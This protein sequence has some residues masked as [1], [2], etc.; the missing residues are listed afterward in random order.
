[1]TVQGSEIL[2]ANINFLAYESSAYTAAN[3]SGTVTTTATDGTIT[4]AAAHNLKVGDPVNFTATTVVTTVTGT[5]TNGNI[6]VLSSTG[7]VINMPVAFTG[8]TFG[9][10][11]ISTVYYIRSISG[12]TVTLS[13]AYPASGSLYTPS[14]TTTGSATMTVGGLFVTCLQQTNQQVQHKFIML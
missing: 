9:G 11:S 14:S 7:M 5:N 13:T 3:Y 4:T 2:R 10:L 12:T 8:A 1:M 6:T